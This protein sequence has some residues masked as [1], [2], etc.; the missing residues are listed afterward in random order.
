[1]KL[2]EDPM[3]LFSVV[4]MK[5]RDRYASLDELCSKMDVD[6]DMLV[7][8]LAI[9]GLYHLF[10]RSCTRSQVKRQPESRPHLGRRTC[11]PDSG[12][13]PGDGIDLTGLARIEA[14]S[15]GWC[16]YRRNDVCPEVSD[17]ER[18]SG[19]Q[20]QPFLPFHAH[21]G[22]FYRSSFYP[23]QIWL[24]MGNSGICRSYLCRLE[25]YVC[26]ET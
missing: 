19:R 15:T 20:R 5:L 2:P 10:P 8:K 22:I 26:Q 9:A 11:L 12:S 23:T 14:R 21:L 18:T 6:K 24:E 16:K 13:Q 7:H 17:Q 4:N 25:P 1:M 3:M